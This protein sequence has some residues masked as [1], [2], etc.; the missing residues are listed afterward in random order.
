MSAAT[1][2]ATIADAV[3]IGTIT[4]DDFPPA[5][6]VFINEFHYDN[7]S[8]DVGEF[9]EIAGLA[10]TDLSGWK[11]VLYN[12]DGGKSYATLNLSGVIVDAGKG[13]GFVSVARAGIQNDS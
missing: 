3:A 8:T 9:I 1:G 12:G 4:T 10:G 2:G 7:A 13:F 5:A 6:N 11:L